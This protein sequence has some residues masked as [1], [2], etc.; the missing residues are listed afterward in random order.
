MNVMTIDHYGDNLKR[1]YFDQIS[2]ANQLPWNG[3]Y[4]DQRGYFD[5]I[6]IL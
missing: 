3:G 5:H 6:Q 4:F 1:G 2:L